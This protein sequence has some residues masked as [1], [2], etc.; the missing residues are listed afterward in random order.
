MYVDHADEEEEGVSPEFLSENNVRFIL[1]LVYN[2]EDDDT[3]AL[4]VEKQGSFT[5]LDEACED[6]R[7]TT[8]IRDLQSHP[9]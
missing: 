5:N 8:S 3:R 7:Y 4:V 9:I 1:K 2:E 6:T